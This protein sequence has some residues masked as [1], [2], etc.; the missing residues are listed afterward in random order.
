MGRSEKTSEIVPPADAAWKRAVR[1]KLLAWFRR[2]ARD[3]PWRR[4]RDPYAVWISEMMLQQTQVATVVPYFKRFL[5]EFP[6]VDELAAADESRVLRLWEGLGYYRRARQLHQSARLIVERHGGQFPADAEQVMALP[7]I[8]RY[9]AGAVL[10]IA[11]DARLPILEANSRRLIARLL[12]E[13]GALS[14]VAT[15]RRLWEFATQLL[16]RKHVGQFNQALMELGSD[17]CRPRDPECSRCPL[18][19]LCPT[20]RFGWQ[21]QIPLAKRP[22]VYETVHHAAVVVRRNRRVL[23]RR[24]GDAERWAGMWDFPRF[25]QSA[26]RGA[27]LQRELSEKVA[28]LTGVAIGPARRTTTIRH[29]V[30]RYRITLLC[31]EAESLDA[32]VAR[33]DVRWVHPA[34]LDH[35]PL[36]VT[37]RKIAGGLQERLP[38]AGDPHARSNAR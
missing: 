13:R 24:C 20:Q 14:S 18:A 33:S 19:G 6:S 30:T 38:R 9:T 16:P 35:M 26:R 27:A 21:Q 28:S 3:L 17:I 5:A 23:L 11:F 36:N 4:T 29:G 2:H 37:A 31:Y 8:G 10:S 34:Q 7:G 32:D 22:A 25:E 15:D 1:Q 12:A